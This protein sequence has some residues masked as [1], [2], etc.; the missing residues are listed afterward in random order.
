MVH[1]DEKVSDLQTTQER[2]NLKLKDLDQK[3]EPIVP[4]IEKL[5]QTMITMLKG[6][7]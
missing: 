3:V 6:G 1:L 7:K 4:T 5:E 2:L